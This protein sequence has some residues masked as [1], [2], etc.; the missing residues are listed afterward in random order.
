MI[1]IE[2]EDKSEMRVAA[3]CLYTVD[4]IVKEVVFGGPQSPVGHVS[5][6]ANPLKL[7]S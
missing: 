7:K 2:I 3:A 6:T 5:I 1:M 4:N